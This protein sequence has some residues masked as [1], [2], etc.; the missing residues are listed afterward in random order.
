MLRTVIKGVTTGAVR[1]G[2]SDA[3]GSAVSRAGLRNRMW[4]TWHVHQ[5]WGSREVATYLTPVWVDRNEQ[6]QQLPPNPRILRLPV[7][8]SIL[9]VHLGRDRTTHVMDSKALSVVTPLPGKTQGRLKRDLWAGSE[10][11]TAP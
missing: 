1:L 6:T 11:R 3:A 7:L 10:L 9:G 4:R 8:R 2:P 5:G